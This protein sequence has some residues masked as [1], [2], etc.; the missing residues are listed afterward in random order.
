MSILLF[1]VKILAL[2]FF[3]SSYSPEAG[4][5]ETSPN[6]EAGTYHIWSDNY[7]AGMNIAD[8]NVAPMPRWTVLRGEVVPEETITWATDIVQVEGPVYTQ[9]DNPGIVP[10]LEDWA[11]RLLLA[12]INAQNAGDEARAAELIAVA[13]AMWDGTCLQ[14]EYYRWHVETYGFVAC[15]TFKVALY[16]QATGSR[17]A[18]KILLRAQERSFGSDNFGGFYSHYDENGEPFPWVDANIETTAIARLALDR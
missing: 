16:Y 1:W 6:I 2:W 8:W 10:R 13:D 15:E 5:L 12:A 14:D 11:D 3:V 7:L 4:L 9:M 18:R 17:E